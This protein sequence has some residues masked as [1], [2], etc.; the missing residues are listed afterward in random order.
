L[1]LHPGTLVGLLSEKVMAD[2]KHTDNKKDTASGEV[3][4]EQKQ[5]NQASDSTKESIETGRKAIEARKKVSGKN[6]LD[7]EK[8]EAKDAEQWRNEG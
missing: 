2:K 7:L 5:K 8:E 3:G 1:A 4:Q 6:E